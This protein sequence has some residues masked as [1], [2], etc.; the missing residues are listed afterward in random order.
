M[1]P[2]PRRILWDD[3]VTPGL[4]KRGEDIEHNRIQAANPHENTHASP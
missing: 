1:V 2:T 4:R 3:V